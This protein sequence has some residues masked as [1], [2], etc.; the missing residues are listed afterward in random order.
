MSQP[1][2]A[3][4]GRLEGPRSPTPTKAHGPAAAQ[5]IRPYGS[6]TRTSPGIVEI[7]GLVRA[8]CGGGLPVVAVVVVLERHGLAGTGTERC[9]RPVLVLVAPHREG[10]GAGLLG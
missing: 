5:A 3:A 9:G 7:P 8:S 6:R 10:S 4:C 2:S 1:L